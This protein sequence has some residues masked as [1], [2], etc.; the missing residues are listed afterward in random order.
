MLKT[1]P[2]SGRNMA[3]VP[4]RR[5]C[6]QETT[7]CSGLSAISG[8]QRLAEPPRPAVKTCRLSG[9]NST[10]LAS[11]PDRVR[12]SRPS[13]AVQMR[14]VPSAYVAATQLL[15]GLNAT[16]DNPLQRPLNSGDSFRLACRRP[17]PASHK[18]GGK[19]TPLS[20]AAVAIQ[21]PSGLNAAV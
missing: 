7:S 21:W 16:V 15:F 19:P 20:Q 2:P 11:E 18:Q 10:A 5:P 4:A 14:A 17:V 1:R 9:L 3:F 8:S 6:F 13:P 12:S